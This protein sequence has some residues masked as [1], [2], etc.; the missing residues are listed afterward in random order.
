MSPNEAQKIILEMAGRKEGVSSIEI[1]ESH[2]KRH[3]DI[4]FEELKK[5]IILGK[6]I[7]KNTRWFLSNE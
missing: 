1:F 6:I 2:Q 7:Q 4:L 3:S 5:F